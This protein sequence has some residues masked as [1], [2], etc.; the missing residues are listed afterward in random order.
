M[1]YQVEGSRQVEEYGGDAP[2][3][4]SCTC[5]AGSR[6]ESPA[7]CLRCSSS[8]QLAADGG[9]CVPRRCQKDAAGRV[10]C[11]KCPADYIAVTQNWDGSP[12]REVQCVKCARGYRAQR[13]AC[14][15]CDAC[16]CARNHV[17]VR[18]SCVPKAFL[19]SRPKYEEKM[20]TANELLDV[21]KFEYLC[22]LGDVRACRSLANLCVR[23]SYTADRGGP[24]RLWTQPAH[25]PRP[26]GNNHC[27]HVIVMRDR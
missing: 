22:T 18:G 24:C 15:R 11:R 3:G 25:V 21:V 14:V 4:F 9:A 5:A 7:R 20:L 6:W 27:F 17:P 13:H 16:A 19:T 26:A 10:A 2:A 1:V 12:Q 23:N 8:E